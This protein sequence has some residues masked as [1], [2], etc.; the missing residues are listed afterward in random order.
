MPKVENAKILDVARGAIGELLDYELMKVV[1]NISDLNTKAESVRKLTITVSFKP[2]S[3]RQNIS[4]STQIKPTLVPT[5][6]VETA[7]YLAESSEGRAL[8]EMVP[9]TPGQIAFDGSE[10]EQPKV[11]QIKKAV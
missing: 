6:N 9:Q 8:V 11:I 5:N 10:Q 3:A 1:D 2:D 7:L 4:M